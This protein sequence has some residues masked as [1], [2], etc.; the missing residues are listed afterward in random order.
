M[1]NSRSVRDADRHVCSRWTMC[2]IARLASNKEE[3]IGTMVPE[4]S[5]EGREGA[6][7]HEVSCD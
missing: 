3:S 4:G 2:A 1:T 7:T 5:G 6:G